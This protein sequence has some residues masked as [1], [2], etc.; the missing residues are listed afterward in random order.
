MQSIEAVQKF[1]DV[2][3]EEVQLADSFD[4]LR[5]EF[6]NGKSNFIMSWHCLQHWLHSFQVVV[7]I[8]HITVLQL[9]SNGQIVDEL[10]RIFYMSE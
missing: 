8:L 5:V 6:E 10:I 4:L 3:I 2:T 7:V 1:I 9:V